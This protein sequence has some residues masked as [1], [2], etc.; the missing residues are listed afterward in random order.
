MRRQHS[1]SASSRD[2]FC[3]V[4][5]P[6]TARTSSRAA[7]RPSSGVAP[8]K[9][10]GKFVLDF[11]EPAHEIRPVPANKIGRVKDVQ[12]LRYTARSRLESAPTVDDI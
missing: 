5:S 12:S 2:L 11:A 7:F 3:R 4:S 1:R 10:S 6:K 9:D 8:W